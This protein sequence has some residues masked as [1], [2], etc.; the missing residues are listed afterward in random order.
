MKFRRGCVWATDF[1]VWVSPL[2]YSDLV[3]LARYHQ[4]NLTS[5]VLVL[6]LEIP[7]R[8]TPR[9]T[10]LS[11]SSTS[12]YLFKSISFSISA[13]HGYRRCHSPPDSTFGPCCR[14][15][16]NY[17][18][19]S[20]SRVTTSS[21][22]RR[23]STHQSTILSNVVLPLGSLLDSRSLFPPTPRPTTCDWHTT[24]NP[25]RCRRIS[26]CRSFVLCSLTH[27]NHRSG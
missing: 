4:F 7:K 26:S 25:Q 9:T 19:S 1:V 8:T 6:A 20:T 13:Q 11:L 27:R 15:R 2:L 21:K 12:T 16:T 3:C 18:C 23:I 17:N 5:A 24:W 14:R 10:S 22:S